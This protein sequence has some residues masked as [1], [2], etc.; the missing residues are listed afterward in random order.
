LIF[1]EVTDNNKLA[2]F[3][4]SQRITKPLTSY[5]QITV[6]ILILKL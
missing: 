1:D 4:G 3:Y 2:S 5:R 6:Q